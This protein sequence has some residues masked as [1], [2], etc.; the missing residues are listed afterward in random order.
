V[1]YLCKNSAKERGVLLRYS[2]LGPLEITADAQPIEIKRPR[3]RAVL[4]Y[5][6]LNA[7]K[8][9]AV[10]ELTEALW[11]G[12]EPETA[13][14]QV[15]SDVSALRGAFKAKGLQAPLRTKGAG[16]LIETERGQ[17]DIDDFEGY[18]AS[19]REE[20]LGDNIDAGVRLVT[21]GLG[22]WRG[23]PL[24]GL[25]ASFV[26]PAQLSLLEM[27][28]GAHKLR[29]EL[30]LAAGHHAV[31]V[32]DLLPLVV[33]YPLNEDLRAKLMV[34]LFCCGRQADALWHARELRGQLAE[35]QGLT[36]SQPFLEV[37]GAVLRGDQSLRAVT[38]RKPARPS[39]HP[40]AKPAQLPNEPSCFTGRAGY[41][42]ELDRL[43]FPEAP[44]GGA[45]TV[46]ALVG[47]G[48][49]GKT[50]LA[51]HWAHGAAARFPDGQ[52]YINLRGYDSGSAVTSSEALSRVLRALG[53]APEAIPSDPEDS[54]N[55]FRSLLAGQRMLVVLDNALS[56]D[57]V[58]PLLAASQG[59]VTLITSRSKL[60]GLAARDGA[61]RLQ[62][63]PLTPEEGVDLLGRLLGW[64]W[65]DDRH[66]ARQLAIACDGLPLMLRIVAANIASQQ[67]PR[68]ADLLSELTSG[69]ALDM[70]QVPGDEK[71]SAQVIFDQ[72][73]SKLSAPARRCLR[74]LG[75][76]PGPDFTL[77]PVA[78]LAG[79]SSHVARRLVQQLLEAS[80]ID[81]S[82]P[83]RY[84]MHDLLRT[85]ARSRLEAEAGAADPDR[86]Q[87]WDRLVGWYLRSA[88]NA[89]RLVFQHWIRLPIPDS[90]PDWDP[91]E[92]ASSTAA[93][94]WLDNEYANLAAVMSHAAGA[95]HAWLLA[96][97]LRGYFFVRRLISDWIAA[98]STALAAAASQRQPP[99]ELASRLS[100]AQ[101]YQWF[102]DHPQALRQYE[103][104]L[105]LAQGIG[106]KEVEIACHG[107]VG[108]V[109]VEAGDITRAIPHLR[110]ALAVRPGTV[111]DSNQLVTLS[112]IGTTYQHLGQL[113]LAV[114]IHQ[115][116]LSVARSV[117]SVSGEC[118]ALANLGTA[119][120]AIGD[121]DKAEL[122]IGEALALLR[123]LGDRDVESACL[124]ELAAIRLDVGD[125]ER[126]RE[127]AEEA[128]QLSRTVE[129]AHWAIPVLSM[130]ATVRHDLDEHERAVKQ[131]Y[132]KN[133]PEFI[134]R[135]LLAAAQTAAEVGG[136]NV[137]ESR[138]R[139]AL[140]IA[141]DMGYRVIEGNALI[142][143]GGLELLSRRDG[144]AGA[145]A[146]QAL[147]IHKET[148]HVLGEAR[149]RDLLDRA[150]RQAPP[151][152]G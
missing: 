21:R 37:E 70:L 71:A 53:V 90:V 87:A 9:V 101:A 119:L 11:G 92:F 108:S 144:A 131:A 12:V 16:Y 57:Q 68:L 81:E 96:D 88:D 25:T 58:R 83:G 35:Q 107:H 66:A 133:A 110:E 100:L 41:L 50:A 14:A 54:A 127:L 55:L 49:A 45:A 112:A 102:G 27:Q 31:V 126:A 121:F 61:Q 69:N 6:L 115:R 124:S 146:R 67:R 24:S 111:Q 113:A 141:A 130:L 91:V 82:A 62:L 140:Q 51:V 26:E 43:A 17:T 152:A 148:G 8:A 109:L 98:A 118:Y 32:S 134:A 114:E 137:A 93:I 79:T 80:L 10:S 47:P 151:A 85:Y 122:R 128:W 74:L 125:P 52:L 44:G 33:K 136:R 138:A 105:R 143:I 147:A 64:Q 129:S 72:S 15:Q 42:R 22:L 13:R 135:T 145:C 63:Q 150:D 132:I 116:A 86:A 4:A 73:Y 104:A 34:A 46:I 75:L 89:T 142:V 48:G 40:V 106:K 99:A 3:Q 117:K 18:V 2:M 97:S 1:R 76:I 56:A 149:A 59:T 78:A 19:A 84:I 77:G 20:Y 7:N 36:P 60:T 38:R 123:Q 139:A 103:I 5:L 29:A 23:A 28:L 94:T 30:N 65:L 39:V 120:H 95:P